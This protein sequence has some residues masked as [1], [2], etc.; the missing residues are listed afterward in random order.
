M[1]PFPIE[2]KLLERL[3]AYP[4]RVRQVLLETLEIRDEAERARQIG[5]LYADERSRSFD[6]VLIDLEETPEARAVVVAMVRE[7]QRRAGKRDV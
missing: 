1:D 3:S 2:L 4:P 5:M 6:A 7:M